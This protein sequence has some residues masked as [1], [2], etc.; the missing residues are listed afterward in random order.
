MAVVQVHEAKAIKGRGYSAIYAAC[1][2]VAC[3]QQNMPRTFKEIGAAVP[4]AN[5]KDIGRC[6]NAIDK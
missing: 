2:F 4:D 1:L 6:F 5:K 3:K